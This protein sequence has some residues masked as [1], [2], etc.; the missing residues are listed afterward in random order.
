MSIPR[1]SRGTETKLSV[2][3]GRQSQGYSLHVSQVGLLSADVYAK[4]NVFI[5]ENFLIEVAKP[6]CLFVKKE[7]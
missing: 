4:S 5:I 6:D 1:G 3:Q 7:H 2:S